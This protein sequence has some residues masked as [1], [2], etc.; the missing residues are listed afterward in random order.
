[1]KSVKGLEGFKQ[2]K[3]EEKLIE[4]VKSKVA[5]LNKKIMALDSGNVVETFNLRR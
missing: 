3:E 2:N 5:V 4:S 1:M